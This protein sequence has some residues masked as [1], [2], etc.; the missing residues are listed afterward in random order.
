M[1]RKRWTIVITVSIA[2][3]AT[4][5]SC[6]APPQIPE[7]SYSEDIVQF[8]PSL[9]ALNVI[10]IS[11]SFDEAAEFDFSESMDT[12]SLVC[13]HLDSSD[14]AQFDEA[15]AVSQSNA[16]EVLIHCT[17]SPAA[18][19]VYIGMLNEQTKNAYTLMAVGGSAR[20]ILSLDALPD[21]NYY[22]VMF[23]NDGEKVVAV[24]HFQM[25]PAG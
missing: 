22:P 18:R 19:T 11:S 8:E 6:S 21:G 12:E 25:Q 20:G 15:I 1:A 16:N 13:N 5:T 14:Y 23:S 24:L 9:P 17:W 7:L 4:L 10:D 2:L 3:V